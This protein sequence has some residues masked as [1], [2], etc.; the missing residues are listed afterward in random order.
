MINWGESTFILGGN[1]V[2]NPIDVCVFRR[3]GSEIKEALLPV[4]AVS[5]SITLPEELLNISLAGYYALDWE[6]FQLDPGGTPFARPTAPPSAAASAAT[7]MPS[8]SCPAAPSR[9]IA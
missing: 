7:A 3:P 9:A 5:A 4:N 8:A 6:P 1:N 2:F